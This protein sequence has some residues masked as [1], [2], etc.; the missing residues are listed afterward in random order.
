M[1]EHKFFRDGN[2]DIDHYTCYAEHLMWQG[3]FDEA[4]QESE[5]ARQLDP[6]SV[7]IAADN[8]F[9]LYCARQHDRAIEK[10]RWAREMEPGFPRADMIIGADVEDGKFA[11]ALADL[12]AVRTTSDARWYWG[13]RTYINGRAGRHSEAEQALKQLLRLT[14]QG[15]ADPGLFLWVYIGIGDRDKAFAWLERAFLQRASVMVTLKVDPAFDSL[16]SDP[17]FQNLLK[18]VGLAE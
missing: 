4:L 14:E 15:T 7:I 8:G 13:A 9:I 17:R 2:T 6:L 5:R 12:E 16:R 11:E 1:F 10:F 3:R 18:R